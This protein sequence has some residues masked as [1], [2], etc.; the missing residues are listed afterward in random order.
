M[1]FSGGA[2][3]SWRRASNSVRDTPVCRASTHRAVPITVRSDAAPVFRVPPRGSK[4][5]LP[6]TVNY[7]SSLEQQC[8]RVSFPLCEDDTASGDV[9][10]TVGGEVGE[11]G[12]TARWLL[13][14]TRLSVRP[15]PLSD[16]LGV[17]ASPWYHTRCTLCL[18][19]SSWVETDELRVHALVDMRVSEG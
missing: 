8:L 11:C 19:P 5:T 17:R 1:V 10:D 13:A 18:L 14:S 12:H 16:A 15:S 2:C 4:R 6:R 9:R 7:S 3:C